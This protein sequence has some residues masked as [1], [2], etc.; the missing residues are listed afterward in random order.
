M[1][2][3]P[4]ACL[5]RAAFGLQ[6]LEEELKCK[7]KESKEEP[8]EELAIRSAGFVASTGWQAPG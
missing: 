6:E 1:F 2:C 5:R 7:E 8:K 3:L 4:T